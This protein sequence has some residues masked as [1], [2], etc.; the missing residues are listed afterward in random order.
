MLNF[1]SHLSELLVRV[2]QPRTGGGVGWI[3]LIQHLLLCEKQK[4]TRDLLSRGR[5]VLT[6]PTQDHAL[7]DQC[8][9]EALW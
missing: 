2:A 1:A 9:E 4:H 3:T 5:C 6:A 8:E 7:L